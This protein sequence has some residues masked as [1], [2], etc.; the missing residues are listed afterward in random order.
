MVEA[1]LE[2]SGY[3]V[4]KAED[5]EVALR[6]YEQH[7]NEIRVVLTDLMMPKKDGVTA[8]REMRARDPVA[9]TSRTGRPE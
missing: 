3:R 5:G 8:I 1:T 2:A 4:L 6:L 9:A 7:K